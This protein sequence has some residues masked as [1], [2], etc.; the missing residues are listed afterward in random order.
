MKT[1]YY[2]IARRS[3][4]GRKVYAGD[5]IWDAANKTEARKEIAT[6]RRVPASLIKL[7]IYQR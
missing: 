3:W 4:K 5:G 2:Y 7:S 6:H 1:T